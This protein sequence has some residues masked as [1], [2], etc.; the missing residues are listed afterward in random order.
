MAL[1]CG[2]GCS[3]CGKTYTM[4]T[5]I[6]IGVV[7][8]LDIW[9]AVVQYEKVTFKEFWQR[10]DLQVLFCVT[11]FFAYVFLKALLAVVCCRAC[12][13]N[14]FDTFMKDTFFKFTF[15]FQGFSAFMYM[16]KKLK[17]DRFKFEE[18]FQTEFT[19]AYLTVIL[20][21]LMIVWLY[22]VI[23]HIIGV[24]YVR[25]I[26]IILIISTISYVLTCI[27]LNTD[28]GKKGDVWWEAGAYYLIVVAIAFNSYQVYKIVLAKRHV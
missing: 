18:D 15:A 7:L 22:L 10:L 6:F 21:I 3:C 13:P 28:K 4:A 16:Y 23:F 17:I 8:G 19:K 9:S 12:A 14:F 24:H 5:L 26:I 25:D 27:L 2:C 11:F 20:F 1:G